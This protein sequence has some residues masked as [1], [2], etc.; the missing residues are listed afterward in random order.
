M[1]LSV[2]GMSASGNCYKVRLLLSQIQRD[3]QWFEI[4]VVAG[5]TQHRAFK[6]LN[7]NGKVPLLKVDDQLLPESNAILQFLANGTPLWPSGSWQQAQVL[8]W[9]FFEQYSHEP[10][11]AVARFIRKFLPSDHPRQAEL[12]QLHE[13][14]H[15]AF[16]VMEEHLSDR[17]FFVEDYSIADIALFAYTHVAD[18]AG[19]SLDDYPALRA[20]LA[21]VAEQPGFLAMNYFL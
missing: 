18:E 5:E 17:A 3:Y 10:A 4:D 11:V 15:V 2:Y 12:P 6:V 20:W 14:A 21:R 13:N 7:P 16:K 8:Q 1:G 9:M 19:L